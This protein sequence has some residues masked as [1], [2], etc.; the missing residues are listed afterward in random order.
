MPS[1]SLAQFREQAQRQVERI[2]S[3]TIVLDVG[4]YVS[5]RVR[6]VGRYNHP[7]WGTSPVLVFEPGE[8]ETNVAV[9]P[10][11]DPKA[12]AKTLDLAKIPEDHAYVIVGIGTVLDKLGSYQPGDLAYIERHT[13]GESPAG[14]YRN[15]SVMVQ[16]G[17]RPVMAVDDLVAVEAKERMAAA[18]IP[19]SIVDVVDGEEP[20]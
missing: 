6:K 20:F 11:P 18:G 1:N 3:V 8:Q 15:Y 16:R 9:V 19:T 4:Q 13:D 12:K 17:T 7:Q 5:G 2:P 14:V 10:N